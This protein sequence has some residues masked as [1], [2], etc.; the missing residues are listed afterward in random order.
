MAEITHSIETNIDERDHL[1]HNKTCANVK[2]HSPT[3]FL[4][5]ESNQV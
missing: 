4:Y 5:K 3:S 2:F 1:G